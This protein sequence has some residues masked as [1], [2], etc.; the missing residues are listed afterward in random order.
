MITP[1]DVAVTD[2]MRAAKFIEK[3]D[4]PVLGGHRE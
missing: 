3:L 2:A 1:Q 4:L